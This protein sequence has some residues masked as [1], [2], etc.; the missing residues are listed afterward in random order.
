MSKIPFRQL[1]HSP[2]VEAVVDIDCDL[3]PDFVLVDWEERGR[4]RFGD[5][6]GGFQR[7]FRQPRSAAGSGAPAVLDM[8][9][10]TYAFQFHGTD[11][12]QM[13]QLRL[14][15]FSFNRLAPYTV[16]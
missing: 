1:A 13:V 15:G 6:Y 16:L 9:T 11:K 5:E 2:I 12:P 10:A 4:K 14:N 3:P 7:R 8:K